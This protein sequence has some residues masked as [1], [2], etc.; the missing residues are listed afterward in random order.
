M[1]RRVLLAAVLAWG[2]AGSALA[3]PPDQPLPLG[4][5]RPS[6]ATIEAWKDRKFGLFIHFGLYSVAGGMW[7]GKRIDNGY[8]EQIFANGHLPA[9]DYAALAK[10][11]D[12]QKFDPDAIAELAKA[13]G[14]K[15]IVITAK[16]HD[17]F[18]L[19]KT[20]QT[21]Y[22]AVDGTPYG[23]DIVREMAEACARHGLAFGVYYSTIDWHHPGGNTYLEG[24]SNPIT[25]GQAAFNV[26]QIKE[27]LGHYGPISEIW[28]DMGK[29]TPKQSARFAQTVHA[30]QPQTMVSGR[31]WNHQ[32][33]FTVM[34]DNGEPGVE[35]EEPWQS[36]ASIYPETW[37]YRSWQARNDLKGKVEEH[38]AR[39]VRVVSHGG[40][41]ILNIGPEG[42][43]SV[44]P[45]EADVLRGMGDWMKVNGE[46][47]YATQAQPFDALDFGYATVGKG[48]L[49]LFVEKRPADGSLRLPRLV[50]TRLV[51][52]RLLG[53]DGT[54]LP[55]AV[56]AEGGRVDIS[57]LG[58]TG[59]MPVVAVSF[60]GALHVRPDAVAAG[61]D[62][63]V[64]LA[65]KQ[66]AHFLNYNGYGYA[67]P[68]TVYKL[69]WYAAASAGRYRL[70]IRY[71][72]T[73][74]AHRL[75][76]TVDGRRA[77]ISLPRD[78][79]AVATVERDPAAEPYAMQVELTPVE[80]F[81]KGDALPVVVKEVELR[82]I[83]R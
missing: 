28:F 56:D 50:D 19:F 60:D 27:L 69:R 41:Y 13:A 34:G 67:A 66:A 4:S 20:G 65:E 29:P 52:A 82:E 40:N 24:N 53:G 47:I 7:K 11:F 70:N 21:T 77:T 1:I 54:A 68:E 3:T 71:R 38:I 10:Q 8:S 17:G 79:H 51:S 59:F 14:M 31:V 36:P 6:A 63:R 2:V 76:L 46:S 57:G 22:N 78:G 72:P 26:A 33:D 73:T 5:P 32:G 16:H 55:V 62:G 37:G 45:F 15:F 18:N 12:P 80:P 25:A 64:V 35:V 23:K 9:K 61:K 81:H 42:D 48:T 30:L 75:D 43:G 44:V 58:A 49:Y 39:L 83:S 74:H